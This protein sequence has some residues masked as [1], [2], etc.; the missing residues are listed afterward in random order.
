MK[1]AVIDLGTNTFHLLIGEKTKQGYREILKKRVYVQLGQGG[2]KTSRITPEAQLRAL[3]AMVS[4]KKLIDEHDIKHVYAAATSAVRNATNGK[5]FITRIQGYTDIIV[6][7]ISGTQE[8]ILI[9]EGVKETKTL[10]S[11]VSLIMDIGGGSVEF[12]LCNGQKA[13]W[14]QSFEI[15]AQRLL[16]EFHNHDPI[17]PEELI[18]LEQY[19]GKTLSP[20]LQA[21]ETYQP[22]KLI[23]T[24]GAFGTLV[25]MHQ[26][27]DQQVS[28]SIIYELPL[29]YMTQTYQDIRYM[30]AAERLQI[31]GLA[32][33]RTDMIV[34]S[35]AL[36][37]FVL[38]KSPISHIAVSSYSL[39]MGLFLQALEELKNREPLL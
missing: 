11:E 39:K 38:N 27:Q 35:S 4:F 28:G 17:L 8:S 13:L 14:E 19:L 23:G 30:T 25:A 26:A 21:I 16:D 22:T 12:I 10:G 5:E 3:E 15:G 9:Y 20:L 7:I 32:E 34:V 6:N 24:S 31:P 37:H 18:Q 33:E 36:I 2:F 29:N 1:I